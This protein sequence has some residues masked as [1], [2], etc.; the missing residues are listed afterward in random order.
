[1]GTPV[2]PTDPGTEIPTEEVQGEITPDNTP[3]NTPGLNPAW[4]DVLNL[5]PEQFHSVVTPHFQKWDQAANER[6][7]NLNTQY[8]PFKPFVEHNISYD[9]L[10]NGI[11][12]VN[13][14]NENPQLFY[15]QLG[16]ALGIEK[17][18]TTPETQTPTGEEENSVNLP[19]GYENLRQGVELMAQ[20]M[21]EAEEAQRQQEASAELEAE[22]KA[23]E[24]KYGKF[25]EDLFMPYLS[26]AI[27]KGLTVAQAADS[28]FNAIN[29]TVQQ[30]QAQRPYAPK[31]LSANSGGGAG[32]PSQNIDVTKLSDSDRK[33]LVVRM[34]EAAAQQQG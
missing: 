26:T 34:L 22:L 9:D 21:L 15:E 32:L 31:L 24:T 14:V 20:R 12:F 2:E 1:M 6:I 17:T 13:L 11:R 30:A 33:A 3:D 28:Y 25:N 8:E 5:L 19:P 16:T 7:T 29:S 4:N 10:A 18:E 23:V 27:D